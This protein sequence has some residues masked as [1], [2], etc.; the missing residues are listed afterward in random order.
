MQDS[1]EDG[2]MGHLV[3]ATH[4]VF[5]SFFAGDIPTYIILFSPTIIVSTQYLK[6]QNPNVKWSLVQRQKT[7][8]RKTN[9]T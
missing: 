7:E 5:L 6:S 2:K 1:E 8:G 4:F 9:A 3:N